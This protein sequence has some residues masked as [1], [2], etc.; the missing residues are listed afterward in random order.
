MLRRSISEMAHW[1]YGENGRQ[2]GPLDEN[3]IRA[4][5]GEGRLGPQTLVW[6]EGMAAWQPLSSVSELSSPYASPVYYGPTS[7]PMAGRNS[8]LAVASMVCG[9]SGIALAGCFFGLPGIPAVIC[10]HMALHAIKHSPV[11][12]GGRGMAIA[13]LVMGYLQVL[14]I[15]AFIVFIIIGS[16]AKP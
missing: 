15:I 14:C 10:G 5:I 1:Y 13:G 3:A 4:A 6:C 12:L 8:G 16:V 11:P 9:I 7:I 2:V